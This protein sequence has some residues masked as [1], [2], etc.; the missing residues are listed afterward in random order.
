MGTQRV[1]IFYADK[2]GLNRKY[3]RLDISAYYIV[4]E[5]VCFG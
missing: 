3:L 2:M 5:V 4:I 1:A